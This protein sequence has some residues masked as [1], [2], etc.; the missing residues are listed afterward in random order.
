MRQME[1]DCPFEDCEEGLSVSELQDH[2][3]D[4]HP[5]VF[6]RHT[7]CEKQLK[8][9]KSLKSDLVADFGALFER[10][11]VR[12]DAASCHLPPDVVITCQAEAPVT[13]RPA[14]RS[15]ACAAKGN[16]APSA[17]APPPRIHA[18]S[19]ILKARSEFFRAMLAPREGPRL[20]EAETGEIDMSAYPRETVLALLR[21][22]YTGDLPDHD[23]DHGR[24]VGL[25]RPAH[26]Y[27]LPRLISKIEERVLGLELD[28][29]A[30]ALELLHVADEVGAS[31][32]R[33]EALEYV[34]A[35]KVAVAASPA[36]R[37]LLSRGGCEDLLVDLAMALAKPAA[38]KGDD[39]E[40]ESD[41]EDSEEER[42][43]VAR[44]YAS[45]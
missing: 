43:V 13:E 7:E 4:E 24:L 42:P 17:P 20:R 36:Y 19:F 32:L 29:P 31:K 35:N 9:L 2:L 27:Q 8:S 21:F 44:P 1:F 18:H 45:R 39:G 16:A 30:T 5:D 11:C 14:K 34:E 6:P 40:E 23:Q 12:G 22:L 33:A 15:R 37:A 25:L 38:R 28:D 10:C 41:D 3:L 26:Y